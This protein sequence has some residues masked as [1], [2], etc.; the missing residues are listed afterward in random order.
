MGN[1]VFGQAPEILM[2]V[3]YVS[4]SVV[5]VQSGSTDFSGFLYL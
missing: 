2:L 1:S 3:A 5:R 4:S